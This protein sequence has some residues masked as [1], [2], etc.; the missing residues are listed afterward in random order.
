MSLHK[1][2]YIFLFKFCFLTMIYIKELQLV[3]TKI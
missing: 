2:Q 1:I 3:Q